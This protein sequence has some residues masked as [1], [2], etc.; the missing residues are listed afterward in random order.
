[1]EDSVPYVDSVDLYNE[2]G[3]EYGGHTLSI[4]NSVTILEG[5]EMVHL[6]QKGRFGRYPVHWHLRYDRPICTDSSAEKMLV[7]ST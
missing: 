3:V 7:G 4:G 6:G 2:I 5:L 1:M